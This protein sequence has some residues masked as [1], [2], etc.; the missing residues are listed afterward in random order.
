MNPATQFITNYPCQREIEIPSGFGSLSDYT[1]VS[2]A[3]AIVF[4]LALLAK[5]FNYCSGP[6]LSLTYSPLTRRVQLETTPNPVSGKLSTDICRD[7][8]FVV[9]PVEVKLSFFG[10][11]TLHANILLIDHQKREIELFEPYG[12]SA[13]WYQPVYNFI[14][15]LAASSGYRVIPLEEWCPMA[16]PQQYTKSW[17]CAAITNFYIFS[18]FYDPA[19]PRERIVQELINLG[20][21]NLEDLMKRFICFELEYLDREHL[22]VL[23]S[24]NTLFVDP[25][26]WIFSGGL[27]RWDK[28]TGRILLLRA[29]MEATPATP[30]TEAIYSKYRDILSRISDAIRT[31]NIERGERWVNYLESNRDMIERDIQVLT[32]NQPSLW[33]RLRRFIY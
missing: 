28:I 1:Y 3:A 26:L 10:L 15:E 23:V 31:M 8:R 18:R 9:Q 27:S 20:T 17:I 14:R 21:A 30:V 24:L 29:L 16:G 7:R 6:T 25:R 13:L 19:Y 11:G 4:L 32:N 5:D 22:Q 2:S 33:T 12:P